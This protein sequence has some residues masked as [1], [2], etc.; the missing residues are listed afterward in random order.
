M[1]G[2]CSTRG[3][4][5]QLFMVLVFSVCVS[6]VGVGEV[7]ILCCREGHLD[8]V[9]YLVTEADCDPDVRDDDQDT[10]LHTACRYT[11]LCVSVTVPFSSIYLHDLQ[12]IL[13]PEI[14]L[15]PGL[16]V[17]QCPDSP[18]LCTRMGHCSFVR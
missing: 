16:I 3:Q 17:C 11:L 14:M 5:Y 2:A 8:V 10:P 4:L 13:V 18:F 1:Q 15:F 6:Q 12:R 7:Y 9:R